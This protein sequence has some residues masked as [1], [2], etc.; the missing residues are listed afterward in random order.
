MND[1]KIHQTHFTVPELPWKKEE[2]E[3]EFPAGYFYVEVFWGSGNWSYYMMKTKDGEN[4]QE[5]ANNYFHGSKCPP[6]VINVDNLDYD[7][8]GFH[9]IRED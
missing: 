5:K 9:L 8:D 6:V 7:K 3:M 1:K 2:K 4:P